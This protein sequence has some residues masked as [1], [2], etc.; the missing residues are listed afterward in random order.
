MDKTFGGYKL[1]RMP[2]FLL[3]NTVLL[4]NETE[5]VTVQMLKDAID[6]MLKCI[7]SKNDL[8][9]SYIKAQK[10]LNIYKMIL[11]NR[12]PEKISKEWL[13]ITIDVIEEIA[14]ENSNN[15]Y[16]KEY[17]AKMAFLCKLLID[18]VYTI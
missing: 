3:P 9:D 18:G 10:V 14:N 11:E 1:H 8:L 17:N 6:Y 4:S 16:Q 13:K 12:T 2:K 15:D 5:N 7:A